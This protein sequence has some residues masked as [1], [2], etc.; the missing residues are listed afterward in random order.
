MTSIRYFK[1]TLT[2]NFQRHYGSAEELEFQGD[3][4]YDETKKEFKERKKDL[5]ATD[6]LYGS[7]EE[8]QAFIKQFDPL[9]VVECIPDD[10][11][12]SAEWDKEDF[13]ISFII[14]VDNPKKTPEE[15]EEWLRDTSLEDGEYESCGTS[16]W[17]VKT[18]GE[19]M[20]YGV[21]DYRGNLILV[22]EVD[23]KTIIAAA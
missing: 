15:I 16:A 14:K 5:K 4:F 6:E 10:E 11:V 22:E 2:L 13:K 3:S 8:I 17:T 21:T 19:T 20:E 9:G 1:V 23:P 12:I 18:L 7:D